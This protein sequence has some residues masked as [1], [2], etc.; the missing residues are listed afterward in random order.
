MKK[1]LATGFLF[2]KDNS[3]ILV[4]TGEVFDCWKVYA[5]RPSGEEKPIKVHIIRAEV[6]NEKK[7]KIQGR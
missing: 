2:F 6:P 5:I 3:P 7:R 1:I 4:S